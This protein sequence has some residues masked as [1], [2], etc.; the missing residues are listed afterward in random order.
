MGDVMREIQ[1]QKSSEEKKKYQERP[2]IYAK[3]VR[4]LL[5]EARESGLSVMIAPT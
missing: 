2:H 3:E 4:F 1:R 5:I